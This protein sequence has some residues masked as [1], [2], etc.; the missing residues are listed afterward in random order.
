MKLRLVLSSY[1]NRIR[2]ESCLTA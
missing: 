2:Q 1:N